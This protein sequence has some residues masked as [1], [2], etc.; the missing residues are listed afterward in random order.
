MR[1]VHEL[2]HSHLQLADEL[3]AFAL[4]ADQIRHIAVDTDHTN[5][6]ALR[7]ADGL[8]HAANDADGT[9][10]SPHPEIGHVLAVAAK[11]GLDVSGGARDV[12]RQKAP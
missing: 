7:T 5:G 8:R 9:V 1:L 3:F 12:F 6:P 10:P 4:G 11:R 2:L